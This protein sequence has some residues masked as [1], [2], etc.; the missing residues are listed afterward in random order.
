MVTLQISHISLASNNITDLI[1]F[2]N[3]KIA[4][5]GK[6]ASYG[7]KNDFEKTFRFILRFFVTLNFALKV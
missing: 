4:H 7:T 2:R 6:L 5:F 1:P 3:M